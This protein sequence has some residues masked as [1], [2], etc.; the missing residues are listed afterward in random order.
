MGELDRRLSQFAAD[1]E[2]EQRL[3]SDAD[4]ALTRLDAEDAALKDEIK[5]SVELRSGVDD[6]RRRSRSDAGR[7][8]EA[9]SPN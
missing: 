9:S 1:I 2:R 4:V 6:A 7:R 5:R 3:S 8:R